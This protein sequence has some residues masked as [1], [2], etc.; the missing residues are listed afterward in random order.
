MRIWRAAPLKNTALIGDRRSALGVAEEG[1][2]HAFLAAVLVAGAQGLVLAHAQPWPLAPAMGAAGIGKIDREGG[3]AAFGDGYHP[4]GVALALRQ[5][6]F[7]RFVDGAEIVSLAERPAGADR[8][9]AG[10]RAVLTATS[11]SVATT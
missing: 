8:E 1:A 7:A 11:I 5:R 2:D 9:R 3:T 10:P 4:A 6:A